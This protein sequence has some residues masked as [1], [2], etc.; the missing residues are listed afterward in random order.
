AC[1]AD[2]HAEHVGPEPADLVREPPNC[3]SHAVDI[4]IELGF[5]LDADGLEFAPYHAE[6]TTAGSLAE[7]GP[8]AVVSV[9]SPGLP[10]LWSSGIDVH[11]FIS[12]DSRREH[13]YVRPGGALGGFLLSSRGLPTIRDAIVSPDLWEFLPDLGDAD[14]PAPHKIAAAQD[15]SDLRL[16]VL[17]PIAPRVDFDPIL[18]AADVEGYRI[19]SEQLGWIRPGPT[20]DTLEALLS[21]IRSKLASGDLGGARIDADRFV[22]QVEEDSCSELECPETVSLTAEAKGLLGIN[23]AFLRDQ[24]PDGPNTQMSI[25]IRPFSEVNAVIPGSG[26]PLPVAILGSPDFDVSDV[27][28]S[29]IVFGPDKASPRMRP[30]K[31]RPVQKDVNKDGERDLLLVFRTRDTGIE[32]GDSE[33]CLS[34]TTMSGV[35]L[36]ACDGIVTRSFCGLGFEL[37]LVAPALL[38]RR[39]GRLRAGYAR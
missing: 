37:A 6:I 12:W 32:R 13:A 28:V 39:R 1:A 33:A 30:K 20:A 34:A 38:W 14:A 19:E 15:A 36:E 5:I 8:G 24:L 9:G 10:E 2:P 18:F 21:S 3:G 25:D 7:L 27:D 16:R 26:K 23:V 31:S 4:E 17:G 29:S 35:A 11:G 22:A